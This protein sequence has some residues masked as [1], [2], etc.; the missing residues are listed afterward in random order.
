[1]L[2]TALDYAQLAMDLNNIAREMTIHGWAIDLATV[3]EHRV[4][5]KLETLEAQRAFSSI[6]GADYTLT[7]E[8]DSGEEIRDAS[9]LDK[10]NSLADLFFE[11]WGVKPKYF[12]KKTGEP[13]LNKNCLNDLLA[14]G[15]DQTKA[16]A[17]ALLKYREASKTLQYLVKLT[18]RI[19]PTWNPC[20][21]ETMRWSASNPNP[22]Q[23]KKPRTDK[24]GNILAAGI[25]DCFIADP[26]LQLVECDKS[27]L[28]LRLMA[29]FANDQKLLQAFADP[30]C[31]IH[32]LNAIDLLGTKEGT[33][34][35]IAKTFVYA[36]L[37]Q[38][39]AETVWRQLVTKFPNLTLKFIKELI[40]RWFTVH[41]AFITY[42][43]EMLDFVHKN[44]YTWLPLSNLRYYY[45]MGQVDPSKVLNTP[46]QETGAADMNC[47]TKRVYESLEDNEWLTAQ[48]HDSLIC[49]GPDPLALAAKMKQN[50]DTEIH[51]KGR[52]VKLPVDVKYGPIWGKMKKLK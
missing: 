52:S 44:G 37:Y 23:I 32:D 50:M 16:A 30:K 5:L 47:A 45:Y 31:D 8:D 12:S 14:E 6:A 1:M 36:V 48:M 41:P 9:D 20:A 11:K 49:Q 18:A 10:R 7:E 27:Q 39:A 2:G 35:D 22:Q 29:L 51:Y 3:G 17:R 42:R 46:N 34:R 28:E 33:S 40:K 21:A 26:G 4:R 19:H 43:E 38:A 13:S 15:N 25:R 24:D